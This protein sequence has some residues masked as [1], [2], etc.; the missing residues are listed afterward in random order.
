MHWC[1]LIVIWSNKLGY[2]LR[3]EDYNIC[4]SKW[5]EIISISIQKVAYT[6]FTKSNVYNLY[7][8]TLAIMWPV[9]NSEALEESR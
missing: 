2:D 4:L 8:Y 9:Y 7:R 1:P 3:Y 5:I 6:I